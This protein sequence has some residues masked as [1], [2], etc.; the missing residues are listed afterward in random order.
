M[1][2]YAKENYYDK[3]GLLLLAKGQKITEDMIKKLEKRDIVL[4]NA[5]EYHHLKQSFLVSQSANEI[6]EKMGIRDE[7]VVESQLK[8]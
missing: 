3:N 6:K 2:V 5:S 7:A 8:Y 1:E 4:E